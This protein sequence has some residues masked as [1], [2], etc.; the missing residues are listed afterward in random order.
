MAREIQ[1]HGTT[2]QAGAVHLAL[3]RVE[4]GMGAI[5]GAAHDSQ[6]LCAQ[7]SGAMGLMHGQ[8]QQRATPWV[9]PWGTARV[10]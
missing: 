7:L 9:G 4:S 1:A 8:V 3:A 6:Q 5:V 2:V 10:F